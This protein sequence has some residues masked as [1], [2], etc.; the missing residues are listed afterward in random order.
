MA[1]AYHV[2]EM[3]DGM[4][5]RLGTSTD[6][7][8]RADCLTVLNE[9]QRD[10][11]AAMDWF[12]KHTEE[13]FPFIS[14]TSSYVMDDSVAD[15]TRISD[16][17]GVALDKESWDNYSRLYVPDQATAG[18]GVIWTLVERDDSSAAV[19]VRIWPTP[20]AT[21]NGTYRKENRATVL[22]DAVSSFSSFPQ[23]DR[24]G[25]F[26]GALEV[27]AMRS[28]KPQLAQEY[29]T[30]HDRSMLSLTEKNKAR[31]GAV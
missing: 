21:E 12:F 26:W 22:T 17:N 20:N 23:E 5:K 31:M 13:S 4:S 30:K 29:K 9:V 6:V 11:W 8:L 25:L 7:E 18:T 19:E 16:V 3:I 1:D 2:Q 15:V 10:L 24:M 28:N 14:G 27:M